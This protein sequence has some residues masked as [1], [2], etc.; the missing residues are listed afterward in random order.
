MRYG[1][2]SVTPEVHWLKT[3]CDGGLELGMIGAT[4]QMDAMTVRHING[5]RGINA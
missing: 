4:E 5:A 3:R 2:Y 1:L